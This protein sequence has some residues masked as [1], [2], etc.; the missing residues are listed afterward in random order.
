LNINQIFHI[1]RDYFC[2]YAEIS[3]HTNRKFDGC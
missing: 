3:E 1:S 2:L